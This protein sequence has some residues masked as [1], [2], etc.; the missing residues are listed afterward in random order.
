MDILKTSKVTRPESVQEDFTGTEHLKGRFLKNLRENRSW[1]LGAALFVIFLFMI[2]SSAL[3]G[4]SKRN[5][6][7]TQTE[8]Q[9]EVYKEEDLKR[10]IDQMIQENEKKQVSTKPVR[11]KRKAKI[12][13]SMMQVFS[14]EKK[15]QP[16][17]SRKSSGRKEKETFG[18]PPGTKIPASLS[19]SLFSFNVVAP[20]SVEVTKDVQNLSGAVVVPKGTK[21]LGQA[22][23]LKSVDRVNVNFDQ[24]VLPDGR[25]IKVQAIALSDDGSAGLRGKVRKHQDRKIFKVIGETALSGIGLFM[26]ARQADPFSLQDQMAMNFAENMGNQAGRDLKSMKVETSVTVESRTPVQV[27]LLRGI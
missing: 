9:H 13:A 20:V 23:L 7:K 12:F 25:V 11:E 21:M 2:L 24:M 26:G 8:I 5:H 27:L 10:V 3:R 17:P 16:E 4:P 15:E 18:L 22:G 6:G 1:Q 19:G 14:Y